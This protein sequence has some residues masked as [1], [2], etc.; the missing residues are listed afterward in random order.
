M[1]ECSLDFW[2]SSGA[3]YRQLMGDRRVQTQ[4]H[5][6]KS[7]SG[8]DRSRV[9]DAKSTVLIYDRKLT[10]VSP[11][12]SKFA[13]SF[14]HRYAVKSGEELKDVRAFP[15]HL[16]KLSDLCAELP[17]RKMTVLV[18]GGGSVGDF[19]GFFASVFKRGVRL[20][21]LPTTWLAAID[22]AHGGK[23]A[24]NLA[25]TKNQ[26]GTFYPATDVLLIKS[27]LTSQPEA[28]VVDGLG[29]LA[30]IALI[31][32]GT[33]VRT[34]ET[35]KLEGADLIWSALPDAIA[36]KMRVV[37]S[38][39]EEKSGRRQVLNLGHTM[40]HVLE[41]YNGVS[42]G[43][44]VAQGLFFAVEL[45][46]AIGSL[47]EKDLDRALSL[48]A[49]FGLKPEPLKSPLPARAVEAYLLRDKK[50]DADKAVT[51]ILLNRIGKTERKTLAISELVRH[52]KIQG[53]CE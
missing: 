25:G 45:S 26:I 37:N 3:K 21:H 1:R 51:F 19:G 11:E 33:W 20:V 47:K 52:A 28:R 14:P 9:V 22:S 2:R 24:L 39:P 4:L 48:I 5:L 43:R 6:L 18:A 34:L 50:R 30:K 31:D 53:W 29:E 40:G 36:A 7:F 44:A 38:D 35:T 17:P 12:F 46:H 49:R 15:A 27:I 23:T 41:A 16:K 8:L 10:T 32:G 13:S 42:H